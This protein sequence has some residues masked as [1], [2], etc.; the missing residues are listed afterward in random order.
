MASYVLTNK[1]LDDLSQIWNY[2]FEV[3]SASQAD[4]YYY[5]ILDACEELGSG[6]VR[7]KNYP[8]VHP[9]ISGYRIGQHLIFYRHIRGGKIEVARILHSRMDFKNRISG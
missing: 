7:G 2:S 3:W 4:N 1:A 6:K 5:M 9:E 8:E